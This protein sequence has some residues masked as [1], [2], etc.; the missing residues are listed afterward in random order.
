[1]AVK[2]TVSCARLRVKL[3]TLYSV[4]TYVNFLQLTQPINLVTITNKWLKINVREYRR[5]IQ[6][7]QSR[8]TGNIKYTRRRKTKQKHNT[9][10]LGHHYMQTNT[11]HTPH[12]TQNIETHNRTTQK[13]KVRYPVLPK[14]FRQCLLV[15]L[16]LL[17][18]I[19]PYCQILI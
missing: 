18:N 17:S 14:N 15:I 3:E 8:E 1:M 2:L 7:R 19:L 16:F 4:A 6:K 9:L 12:G 10:C 13:T 5:A 11:N